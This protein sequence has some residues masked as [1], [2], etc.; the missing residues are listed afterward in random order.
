ME[1][2][3]EICMIIEDLINQNESLYLEFKRDWYWSNEEKPTEAQWGEFLK[4]FIALVNCNE[5]F[6]GQ[7]KYM[8]IGID[9]SENNPNKRI[10]N[11]SITD[12]NF[13]SILDIKNSINQKVNT[14][15]KIDSKNDN[16]IF[17][18]NNYYKINEEVIGNKQVI[19]FEI[20]QVPYLIVLKKNIQDKNRTEKSNAVFIRGIKESG[21][22]E[23]RNASPDEQR[24][25]NSA[26]QNHRITTKN[27]AIL[28]KALKTQ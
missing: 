3:W 7:K 5:G 20:D 6:I 15:F 24:N 12:G 22:P 9:E 4:D 13:K 26:L 17:D 14:F 16:E 2:I 19:L 1:H 27:K 28:R 10:F 8:I 21:D 11:T 18:I 25:I 23:V